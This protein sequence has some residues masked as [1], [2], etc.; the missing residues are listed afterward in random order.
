M[1]VRISFETSFGEIKGYWLISY[2]MA[3]I[4]NLYVKFYVSSI[5]RQWMEDVTDYC[6]AEGTVM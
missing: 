3:E 5:C 1:V 2:I 4:K 6:S